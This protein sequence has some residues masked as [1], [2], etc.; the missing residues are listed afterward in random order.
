LCEESLCLISGWAVKLP[1]VIIW[2]PVQVGLD[3]SELR[4]FLP[5]ESLVEDAD[6]C[7]TGELARLVID[8]LGLV[9]DGVDLLYLDPVLQVVRIADTVLAD[10]VDGLKVLEEHEELEFLL[11]AEVF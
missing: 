5:A 1:F 10:A 4:V 6:Y 7:H 2:R 3:N 8:K 11:S 9:V